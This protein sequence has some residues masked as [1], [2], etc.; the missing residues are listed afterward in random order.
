MSAAHTEPMG[1]VERRG[2]G[3][4]YQVQY[5]LGDRL[6]AGDLV[7]RDGQPTLVISWKTVEWKRVPYICLPLDA[8][9]LKQVNPDVYVYEGDLT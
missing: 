3:S 8:S 2:T 9:R 6:Y 5:R 1:A 4:R 7:F